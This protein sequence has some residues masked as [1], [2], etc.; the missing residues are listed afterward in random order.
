MSCALQSQLS[1]VPLGASIVRIVQMIVAMAQVDVCG[2][3]V[4]SSAMYAA[5]RAAALKTETRAGSGAPAEAVKALQQLLDL[6]GDK[7]ARLVF[8]GI[9][10]ARRGKWTTYPTPYTSDTPTVLRFDLGACEPYTDA[11]LTALVASLDTGIREFAAMYPCNDTAAVKTMLA[12]GIVSGMPQAT[13]EAHIESAMRALAASMMRS[14]S[15]AFQMVYDGVAGHPAIN[16][17]R[18]EIA[19]AFCAGTQ[20]PMSAASFAEHIAA[21]LVDGACGIQAAL[22][23]GAR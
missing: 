16:T 22:A 12:S 20:G 4:S 11:R 5:L 1:T 9:C 8:Q 3:G 21:V 7:F 6:G 14:D 10:S 19:L 15:P 13:C 23:K 18:A 17:I 2:L